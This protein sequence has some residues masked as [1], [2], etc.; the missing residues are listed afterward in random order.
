MKTLIRKE[1]QPYF[2][3]LGWAAISLWYVVV[4]ADEKLG[5][6]NDNDQG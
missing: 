6:Y 1:L 2:C 5:G 3:I 4:R